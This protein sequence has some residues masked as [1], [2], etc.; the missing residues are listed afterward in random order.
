MP[1]AHAIVL[2]YIPSHLPPGNLVDQ[3]GS[4]NLCFLPTLLVGKNRINSGLTFIFEHLHSL[5]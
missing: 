2:I 4:S 3:Y 5:N 1:V